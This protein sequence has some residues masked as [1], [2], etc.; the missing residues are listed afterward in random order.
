[1]YK[2]CDE[3]TTFHARK[4]TENKTAV[5]ALPLN[6]LYYPVI[7]LP[8]NML[9]CTHIWKTVYRSGHHKSQKIIVSLG[10]DAV[11]GQEKSRVWST[12]CFEETKMLRI[13]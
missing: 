4:R 5:I 3:E 1:M 9:W 8:L 10:E 7:A 2:G 11:K 12:P 13:F 6:M